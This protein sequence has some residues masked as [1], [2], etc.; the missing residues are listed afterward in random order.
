MNCSN[1][2]KIIKPIDGQD[3]IFCPY[4][5]AKNNLDSFEKTSTQI[6]KLLTKVK[7]LMK[8]KDFDKA[9][10]VL[11]VILELDPV[12]DEASYVLNLINKKVK[13]N[14]DLIINSETLGKGLTMI[15]FIDGKQIAQIFRKGRQE[16]QIKT[17]NHQLVVKNSMLGQ[18]E[19]EFEV[20]Q[21]SNE[22]IVNVK[23]I[24]HSWI[25]FSMD[26]NVEVR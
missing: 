11:E 6:K 8:D 21:D 19:R 9:K 20:S 13:K 2:N 4:C 7:G 12:N 24:K 23:I 26:V 14:V 3:Y 22:V 15:F 5:G 25:K 17:G 10:T 18:V 16:G 1:C